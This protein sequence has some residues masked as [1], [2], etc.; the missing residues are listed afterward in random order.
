MEDPSYPIFTDALFK[1]IHKKKVH[2]D[3]SDGIPLI[4]Y[5]TRIPRGLHLSLKP[6]HACVRSAVIGQ[7]T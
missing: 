7:H 2:A 1:L 4:Q 6:V 5:T 3:E